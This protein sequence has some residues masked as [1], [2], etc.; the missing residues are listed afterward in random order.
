MNNW[1]E[2]HRSCADSDTILGV[3]ET[4]KESV[5]GKKP[6][7]GEHIPGGSQLLLWIQYFLLFPPPEKHSFWRQET[8][9]SKIPTAM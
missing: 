2:L 4:P 3:S 6:R 9:A 7:M 8:S 1:G 5:K